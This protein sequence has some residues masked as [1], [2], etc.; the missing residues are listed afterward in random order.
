MA[1]TSTIAEQFLAAEKSVPASERMTWRRRN[2]AIVFCRLGVSSVGATVGELVLLVSV[3]VPRSWT[4][5]LLRRSEEVVR[6]DLASPPIRHSNPPGR[7]PEFPGKV[8]ALEHEHRWV[9]GFGVSCAVPL[10]LPASTANDH[11]QALVAFCDRANISFDTTYE[12]PPPPGEQL[13]LG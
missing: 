13:Q 11:R 6:W 9:Q 4:L 12:Q 7:P 10:E 8:T 2:D 5:E 1:L 3:V